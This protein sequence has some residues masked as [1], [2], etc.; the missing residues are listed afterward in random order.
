MRHNPAEPHFR[1][2]TGGVPLDY[3]ALRK[4]LAI[5]WKE[6]PQKKEIF[7]KKWRFFVDDLIEILYIVHRSQRW[8]KNPQNPKKP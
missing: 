6:S 7:L 4:L 3:V 5:R 1:Q 2:K 8:L